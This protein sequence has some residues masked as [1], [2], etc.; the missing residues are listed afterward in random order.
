MFVRA[1]PVGGR[2]TA[3]GVSLG[4]QIV[5]A[6]EA[7]RG[8]ECVTYVSD[9]PFHAALLVAASD[10]DGPGFVMVVPGKTQQRGMEADRLATA[11]Q[12]RALQIV[13]LQDTRNAIPRG[14]GGDVA[15]QEVLH[16][17][18]EEAQKDLARVAEHHDERHQRTPRAPDL[19]MAEMPPIDL[20]LRRRR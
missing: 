9:G 10:R 6:G 12:H 7:S 13:V 11:F 8:E 18:R 3:P 4:V 20:P 14:K 17:V 16:G 19:E 2:A 1:T 15:T 5:E